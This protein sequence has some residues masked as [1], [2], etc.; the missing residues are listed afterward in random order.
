MLASV[1]AV[2]DSSNASPFASP[3]Q[4]PLMKLKLHDGDRLGSAQWPREREDGQQR[5]RV[6]SAAKMPRSRQTRP[7]PCASVWATEIEPRLAAD[8]DGRLQ[9]LTVFESLC[10]RYPDRFQPGQ[11]ADLAAPRP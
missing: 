6:P 1:G 7:D 5:E 11:L 4:L 8:T 3:V 2:Q 9:A 10:E